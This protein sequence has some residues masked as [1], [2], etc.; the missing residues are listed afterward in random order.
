MP[1]TCEKHDDCLGRIHSEISDIKV[2]NASLSG[3]IKAFMAGIKE[4]KDKVEVDVYGKEGIIERTGTYGRQV[5]LQWGI[6]TLLL[7]AIVGMFLK[8]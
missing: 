8:K 2:S 4:F 6:L 1:G 3:E 7:L 5:T